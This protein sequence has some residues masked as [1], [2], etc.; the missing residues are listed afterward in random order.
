MLMYTLRM[1]S[2]QNLS[3]EPGVRSSARPLAW[4]LSR[5]AES[6]RPRRRL[7]SGQGSS[8][9]APSGATGT[10]VPAPTP[11]PTSS[12]PATL[13]AGMKCSEPTPPPILRLNVKIHGYEETGIVFDS[14]PD[15]AQRRRLLRQGGLRRLEVL[16]HAAGRPPRARGLRLPRH[17]RARSR[18][19]R[20]G[21]TWFYDDKP[22]RAPI[23]TTVRATTR[24][25][26]SWR[27]AKAKGTYEACAAA[28]LAVAPERHALR[29][30]RAEVGG[31]PGRAP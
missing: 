25:S 31:H 15:R 11:T 22:L 17:R 19:D 28:R 13:P 24:A 16:R 30:L 26:S 10:T 20:W 8:R 5:A 6:P 1:G 21:P 12:K 23:P 9:Q 18:P 3:K 29:H 4:R 27:S 7:R 14:K 2:M